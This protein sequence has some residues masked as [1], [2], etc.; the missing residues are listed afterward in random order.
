MA[1][2]CG[3]S[4]W[5]LNA[6]FSRVTRLVDTR[7]MSHGDESDHSILCTGSKTK[8]DVFDRCGVFNVDILAYLAPKARKQAFVI[9]ARSCLRE[10]ITLG[11]FSRCSLDKFDK[12]EWR[13]PRYFVF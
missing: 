10:W 11:S 12:R 13:F 6:A 7:A 4:E 8:V 2:R 3:K 9:G 1:S 5:M